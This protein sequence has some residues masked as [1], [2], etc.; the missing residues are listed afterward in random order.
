MNQCWRTQ[1]AVIGIEGLPTDIASAGNVIY[2]GMKFRCSMRIPAHL[3]S[4]EI[5]KTLREK[6]TAAGPETYGAL[7]EFE[8]DDFGDGFDAPDL[9]VDIKTQLNEAADEVFGK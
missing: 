3:K 7:I 9:P 2:K 4:E 1:L 8:C 5:V 6:L